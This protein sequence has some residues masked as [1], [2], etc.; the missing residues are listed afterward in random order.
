MV[1]VKRQDPFIRKLRE[2]IVLAEEMKGH[3]E[4][5]DELVESLDEKGSL[6][7]GELEMAL[8]NKESISEMVNALLDI[9]IPD[10]Y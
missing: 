8:H 9:E 1:K 2:L 3:L 4:S 10:M 5:F 7:A 6:S